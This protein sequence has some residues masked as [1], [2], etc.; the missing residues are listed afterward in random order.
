MTR[1]AGDIS[2]PTVEGLAPGSE[3]V[4]LILSEAG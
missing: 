3:G 4:E 1:G 2:S